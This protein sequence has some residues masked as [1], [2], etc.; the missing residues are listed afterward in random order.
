MENR[1]VLGMRRIL[2]VPLL[3]LLACERRVPAPPTPP[4]PASA[5]VPPPVD[6][7]RIPNVEGWT[8][9]GPPRP[10]FAGPHR[11]NLQRIYLNAEA[12]LA[13]AQGRVNP[14]PDGAQMVKEAL[15]RKGQRRGWFWMSKEKGQWVWASAG[16]DGRLEGRQA[17]DA[18]GACAA[19]HMG[20]AAV[21]DG[22]FVPG[23]TEQDPR[24]R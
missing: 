8:S 23:R 20:R 22:S 16:P 9:L 21:H 17:G 15:D 5:P 4:L 12:R 18:S 24:S 2:L 10:S 13:M 19:C 11:G 3:S 6:P 14:W 1:Y 7:T